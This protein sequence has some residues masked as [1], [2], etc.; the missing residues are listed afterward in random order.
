[1]KKY[2]LLTESRGDL[3]EHLLDA[4]NMDQAVEKAVRVL[5]GLAPDDLRH[6]S[7]A[8]VIYA[9]DPFD[10]GD[11]SDYFSL[12]VEKHEVYAVAHWDAQ[13]FFMDQLFGPDGPGPDDERY[14]SREDWDAWHA[15]LTPRE[16]VTFIRRYCEKNGVAF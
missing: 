5:D 9:A 3:F 16:R 2:W 12:P 1:M 4:E 11:V 8:Y 7:A 13:V 14:C 6:T 10:G 15:D